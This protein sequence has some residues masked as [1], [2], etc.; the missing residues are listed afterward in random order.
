MNECT[1]WDVHKWKSVSDFNIDIFTGDNFIS[2][3]QALGGKDISLFAISIDNEKNIC[4]TVWIIFNRFDCTDDVIF[5]SLEINDT[6]SAFMTTTDVTSC[7]DT[8]VI[9]TASFAKFNC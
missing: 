6:I 2:D 1:F 4:V 9:T 8:L 7:N 3:L 5:V